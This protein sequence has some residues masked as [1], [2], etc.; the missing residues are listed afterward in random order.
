M[1]LQHLPTIATAEELIERALKR[2]SKIE[3]KIRSADVRARVTATRKIQALTDNLSQPLKKYVHAF[4]SF[5][6]IH[7]F[8]YA[9]IDLTVS[10]D[11]LRHSLGGIDWAANKVLEIGGDFASKL[12]KA[13]KADVALT[14]MKKGYGRMTSVIRRVSTNL[15]FLIKAR[16]VFRK[17]PAVD[18]EEPIAVFAGAPN[19]GKSSV[20]RAISTGRPEIRAYPFTTKAVSLGHIELK[21]G[22][23]M[24]VMDTPGLL[25]RPDSERNDIEKQGIAAL[26]HLAPTIVFLT[27]CSGTCGYP[28]ETQMALRDE[29]RGRYPEYQWIDVQSKSDLEIEEEAKIE[30][31]LEIST[32]NEESLIEFKKQLI[33]SL[34]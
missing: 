11:E 18:V 22:K 31:T 34:T 27:D 24:Q 26:E 6:N 30:E 33:D 13:R 4:P 14:T 12:S 19:V 17:L 2:S 32:E 15:D 28:M 25:D 9:I 8:D 16:T 7:P 3:E 1:S 29:L 10:V 20:I 5:D 21:Y 23:M